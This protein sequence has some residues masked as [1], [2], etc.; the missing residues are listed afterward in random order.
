MPLSMQRRRSSCW[1]REVVGEVAGDN[2]VFDSTILSR[3]ITSH[4]ITS[5]HITSHH[6]T[7][8]HITSHH[9]TSH[10]ITSHHITSHHI[11]SHHTTSHHITPHHIT[12]HHIT[13]HHITSH[14]ITSH[15]ITSQ[16]FKANRKSKDALIILGWM[17]LRSNSEKH[18]KKSVAFFQGTLK[19]E[20]NN[21]SVRMHIHNK[22]APPPVHSTALH[23]TSVTSQ[24]SM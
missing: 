8:H 11:T 16:V 2:T 12:S 3:D 22:R 15:H 14:H 23:S 18:V 19:I 6:I 20:K 17:N 21:L 1:E 9:I 4:H 13:S 7:S 10:H 24:L 5:H